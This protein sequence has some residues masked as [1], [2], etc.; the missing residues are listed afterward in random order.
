MQDQLGVEVNVHIHHLDPGFGRHG[1]VGLHRLR[2]R[3]RD[4]LLELCSG[5]RLVAAR[6]TGSKEY[7]GR[8]QQY[9]THRLRPAGQFSYFSSTFSTWPTFFWTLPARFSFWPSASRSGLPTT[10]PTFSL[11]LPFTW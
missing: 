7:R 10:C 2:R 8:G 11:T 3:G 5:L 4:R 1:L 6:T 9:V